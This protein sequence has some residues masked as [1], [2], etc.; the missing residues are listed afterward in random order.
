MIMKALSDSAFNPM[1]ICHSL[2]TL[3][4]FVSNRWLLSAASISVAALVAACGGSSTPPP[5]AQTTLVVAATKT[6]LK[7]AK[8]VL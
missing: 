4:N 5:V 6:A 7:L 8:P 2:E 3:M 1:R